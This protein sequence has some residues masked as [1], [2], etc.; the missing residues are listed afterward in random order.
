VRFR[1]LPDSIAGPAAALALAVTL[2]LGSCQKAKENPSTTQT[3]VATPPV[4]S[5]DAPTVLAAVQAPGAK[6]VV[7]NVWA[8]WCEPCREEFPDLVRLGHTY[9]DRGVRMV[10]VSGDFDTEREAVN[11]F[12]TKQ[13]V[14][15]A[16]YMKSG[17]DMKFINTLNPKWSGALP[18]T[19]VYDG[20]GHLRDFWE[21]KASY[22]KME[23]R[24]LRV[25]EARGAA[26]STEART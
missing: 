9:R 2:V 21:G 3:T 19:F 18:A 4:Q 8:T 5:A 15:Y 17:D 22:E 20:Q 26:D 12:L 24:L 16:T 25:L 13:S 6:A 11:Q 23:E 14:D 10:L 1:R 7:L